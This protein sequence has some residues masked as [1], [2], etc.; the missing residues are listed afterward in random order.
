MEIC[1]CA[2]GVF[3]RKGGT[4]VQNIRLRRFR[5]RDVAMFLCT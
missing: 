5:D 2:C 4:L 1:S 3:F